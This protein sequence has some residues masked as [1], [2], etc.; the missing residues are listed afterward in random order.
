M[1][2]CTLIFK[3]DTITLS[4]CI[5]GFW[6]YDYTRGMN[7]SMRAKTEQDAFIGAITYYQ[8]SLKEVEKE[9]NSLQS[10]VD[11]FVDSF[12]VSE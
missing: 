9:F 2:K 11:D 10:K 3:N 5:D 6:L 1:V 8:R 7:L 4:K 12:T